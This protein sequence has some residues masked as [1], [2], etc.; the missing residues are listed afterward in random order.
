M[1]ERIKNCLCHPR[2]IGKYNK[3]KFGKIIFT[4]LLFYIVYLVVFGLRT[5]TENPLGED[6]DRIIVKEII[7]EQDANISYDAESKIL[8]GSKVFIENESFGLYIL[9]EADEKLKVDPYVINIVLEEDKGYIYY[10]FYSVSEIDYS[11]IKASSFSFADISN[12]DTQDIYNF[13]YFINGV[14]ESSFVF[15]RAYNV[16][17][18]AISTLGIYLFIFMLEFIFAKMINPSIDRKVRAKLVLYD[19]AIFFICAMLASLFN[20]GWIVYVGY[21]LPVIYTSITFRHIVKVV[22]PKK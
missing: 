1:L 12:N 17:T 14:L 10:G 6:A 18:G 13:R 4:V 21:I 22:I 5:F 16:V 9:P 15:F 3:D 20:Q 11:N 2:F 19:T 7:A 8:S